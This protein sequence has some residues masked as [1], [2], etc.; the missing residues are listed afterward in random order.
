[1]HIAIVIGSYSL[2]A[3]AS[4]YLLIKA[5]LQYLLYSFVVAL[6]FFGTIVGSLFKIMHLAGADELLMVGLMGTILGAILLV[7]RSFRNHQ[8]H[9]ILNKLIA[10]AMILLQL[11]IAIF[12]PDQSEKSGLL[13]YPI[14][15]LV[16]TVVINEQFDHQGEKGLLLLFMVQGFVYIVI[17]ILRLL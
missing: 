3:A 4:V 17:D 15:A 16:A 10:G 14:T 2:L 12:W 13:N 8:N 7:W 1:M 6:M 5:R 11:A 9:F